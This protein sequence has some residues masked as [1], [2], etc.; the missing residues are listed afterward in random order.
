M[1]IQNTWNDIHS[2]YLIFKTHN[3]CSELYVRLEEASPLIEDIVVRA[4]EVLN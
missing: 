4:D 1:L 2:P 3:L